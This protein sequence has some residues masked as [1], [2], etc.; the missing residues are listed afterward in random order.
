MTF[1]FT[2]LGSEYEWDERKAASNVSKHGVT[3]QEAVEVFADPNHLVDD[4]TRTVHEARN[5]VLGLSFSTR[6]LLV[7][8]T[9]RHDRIR[10]ISARPASKAE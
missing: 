2:F 6:L 5:Y 3:F 4:A 1:I 9:E 10:V 7:V 8:H